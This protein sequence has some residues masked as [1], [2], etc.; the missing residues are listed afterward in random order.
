MPTPHRLLAV[1]VAVLWGVNFLAIHASL[2]H[3]PPFFLVA[4]RW[5]LLAVPAILLVPRPQVPLRWLVGYGLGFG[6]FQFT[7]LYWAMDSGMPVGLASLVLQASAPFTVLLGGVLLREHL[8]PQRILG[9]TIAV[10]GLAIVGSQRFGGATWWPFLLTVVGGLA[11]AFGNISSRQAHPP[12]P[13]HLMMWMTVVPPIPMLAL[14]LAVEGPERIGT[15][16][17]T[18]FT[19]EA[20]P[21][22]VGLLYTVLPATVLAS[23]IWTWLMSR[24]PASSIAPFSMLVPVTGLTTAWLVLGERPN[25]VE[26]IGCAVVVAGVLVG[27]LARGRTASGSPPAETSPDLSNASPL[28]EELRA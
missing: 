28:G 20:V 23:G 12:N 27:A 11:W 10:A 21:A 8:T 17:A 1:L 22:L 13:F 25:T 4:L 24:H 15:S 26:L 18:A 3:F 7:F 9:V 6:T 2:E 14:S 19:A 5:T 16:L